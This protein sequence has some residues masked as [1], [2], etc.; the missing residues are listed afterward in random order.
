MPDSGA[1]YQPTTVGYTYENTGD[2]TR[3][4]DGFRHGFWRI[5]S[6]HK[7]SSR[8]WFEWMMVSVAFCFIFAG[9][10]TLLVVFTTGNDETDTR[11]PEVKPNGSTTI[12]TDVQ[13]QAENTGKHSIAVG[14][15]L[16]LV[17]LLLVFVWICLGFFRPN[18]LQR[19]SIVSSSGQYG[20]VLT[21]VP[22]QLKLKQVNDATRTTAVPLSDQEEETHTLMQDSASP[23]S[24]SA[25]SSTIANQ[26]PG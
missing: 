16:L 2:G 25:G 18:K 21:E 14:T 1:V 23:P 13:Q 4:G 22:S 12:A 10:V 8:R 20:P 5:M 9:L 15:G 11:V 7:L 24:V 3:S 26:I 6:R 17:G 19:S